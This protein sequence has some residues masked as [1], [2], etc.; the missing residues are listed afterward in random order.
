MLQSNLV[1]PRKQ[2]HTTVNPGPV[3][4]RIIFSYCKQQQ[5]IYR[6][7]AECHPWAAVGRLSP[8]CGVDLPAI[9]AS[10]YLF[11]MWYCFSKVGQYIEIVPQRHIAAFTE[12]DD[13]Q[14]VH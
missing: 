4:R 13:D 8:N 3:V 12:T 9:G 6:P 10:I 11:T 14:A 1:A 7:L 5:E 2:R